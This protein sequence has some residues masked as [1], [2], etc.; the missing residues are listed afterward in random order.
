MDKNSLKLNGTI[1]LC[2]DKEIFEIG[3]IID[4]DKFLITGKYIITEIREV[5]SNN[6]MNYYIIAKNSNMLNNFIDV[7]RG[8]ATQENEDKIYKMYVTHYEEENIYERYEV[9]Q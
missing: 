3:K 4:I 5:Y 1:E 2:T 8:E 6:D 7:F 9:V